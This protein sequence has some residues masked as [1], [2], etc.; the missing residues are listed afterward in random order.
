MLKASLAEIL[1]NVTLPRKEL[2]LDILQTRLVNMLYPN[3]HV[4]YGI[5]EQEHIAA[6]LEQLRA[7]HE[8]TILTPEQS[9]ALMRKLAG[10]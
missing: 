4:A 1:L 5:R 7:A 8:H 3:Y 6:L 9:E 2:D 10:K